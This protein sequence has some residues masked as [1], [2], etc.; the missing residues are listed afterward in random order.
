MY[1]LSSLPL[2][3]FIKIK[4]EANPYD[5]AFNKYF[6]NRYFTLKNLLNKFSSVL[7]PYAVKVASMVLRGKC[8]CE[9]MFLTDNKINYELFIYIQNYYKNND[10]IF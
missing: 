4:S 8:C 7:E 3:E 2:K 1:R 6:I 10:K 9:V 5:K